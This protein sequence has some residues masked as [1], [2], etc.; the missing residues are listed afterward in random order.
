MNRNYEN[1]LNHLFIKVRERKKSNITKLN[2]PYINFAKCEYLNA[3][4]QKDNIILNTI[5]EV[6]EKYTNEAIETKKEITQYEKEIAKI[7]E[8]FIKKKKITNLE[9]EKLKKINENI[10]KINKLI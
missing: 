10:E 8:I 2:D 3:S 6:Y 1:Y 4:I 7:I 9:K 5:A